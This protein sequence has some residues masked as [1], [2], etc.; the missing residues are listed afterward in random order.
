M[1]IFP[2]VYVTHIYKQK[3]WCKRYSHDNSKNRKCTRRYV[4]NSGCC[5]LISTRR[6]VLCVYCYLYTKNVRVL[7]V[8]FC[9]Y[10]IQLYEHPGKVF[11]C[12]VSNIPCTVR[13]RIQLLIW[14]VSVSFQYTC[15]LLLPSQKYANTVPR[16][17]DR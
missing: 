15:T 5:Y 14:L 13:L 8:E 2:R 3:L 10:G 11:T 4:K 12:E 9:G 16:V 7:R 1:F 17:K 6:C